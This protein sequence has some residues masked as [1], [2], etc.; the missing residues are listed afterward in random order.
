MGM[1]LG[2]QLYF[3]CTKDSDFEQCAQLVYEDITKRRMRSN[4]TF[5]LGKNFHAVT[6][7]RSQEKP[8]KP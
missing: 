8:I 4:D 3:S 7:S 5:N 1:H 2:G 6:V